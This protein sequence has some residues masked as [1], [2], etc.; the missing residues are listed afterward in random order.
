MK[1]GEMRQLGEDES[2]TFEGHIS[3][4][5][6]DTDFELH[7][8]KMRPGTNDPSHLIMAKGR[9]GRLVRIGTVWTRTT[10]RGENPGTK[11]LSLCFEDPSLPHPINVVAFR[12]GDSLIWSVMFRRQRKQKAA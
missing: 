12:D 3:T 1:I 10:V 11:F 9:S 4:L 8:M 7:P 6:L 2:K 5:L